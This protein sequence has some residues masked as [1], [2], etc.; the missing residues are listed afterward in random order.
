MENKRE[1]IFISALRLFFTSFAA[2]L[3]ISAAIMGIFLLIGSFTDTIDIP[4]KPKLMVS[5]D[6]QG[7]RK[8]LGDSTPVILR[9]DIRGIIGADPFLVGEKVENLLLDSRDG[10]LKNRVKGILLYVN[11]PGGVAVDADD[12][13]RALL[14]YKKKFNVPI[15]A[16]VDGMCASGGMYIVAAAD[17]IYSTIESEIGSVGVRMGPVFNLVDAMNKIGVAS[18][19]LTEGKN[20]DTL[21]PFRPWKE[22]EEEHIKNILAAIYD[23]FVNI[24]TSARPRL[25][26]QKLIN[27]YGAKIFIASKAK[28][29]GYIDDSNADYTTTLRDL[30]K[31]A[32]IKGEYQVLKIEPSQSFL[33]EIAQNKSQLLKGKIE[34]VF[35]LSTYINSD[36]SGKILYLYQP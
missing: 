20:K 2:V 4:D 16:F 35:P 24:V 18:L 31:A 27:E 36:L 34:C 1:S 17:R 33:K 6:D 3:G 30:A 7:N 19:T 29:L 5:P 28:E 23:R 9:M 21:N 11:T 32:E 14:D 26:K 12:I 22:G 15:Y 13:Y 8:L 25:N 10:V